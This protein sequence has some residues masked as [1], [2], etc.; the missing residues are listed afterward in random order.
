MPAASFFAAIDV[1]VASVLLY[2]GAEALRCRAL[3]RGRRGPAARYWGLAAAGLAVLA[4]DELLGL[5]EA[6]GW[7]IASLGA[8]APWHTPRWD[9]V[10]LAGCVL[11][12]AAISLA[13]RSELRQS[14]RT[15][16]LLAAGLGLAG[17]AVTLDTL[18]RAAVIEE[19]LELGA[20]LLIALAMRVRRIE[21][22]T[23]PPDRAALERPTPGD[24]GLVPG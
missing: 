15:L 10:V 11:A 20:A 5:H 17:I 7:L 18:G 13:C 14:G 8:P 9:D 22:R 4:F 6:A 19:L 16:A 1:L 3:L 2:A 12:A 21:A 24:A 23:R